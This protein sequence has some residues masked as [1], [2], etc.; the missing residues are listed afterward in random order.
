MDKT[1]SLLRRQLKKIFGSADSAPKDFQRFVDIVN[2]TYFNFDE[3]RLLL[4][5]SIEISSHELV[6]ANSQMRSI[7][8]AIPDMFLRIDAEGKVLEC[9]IPANNVFSHINPKEIV[10]K[11]IYTSFGPLAARRLEWAVRRAVKNKNVEIAEYSVQNQTEQFREARVVWLGDD[12]LIVI[13]RD[14]TERKL[15][16][17]RLLESRRTLQTLMTNLPG[18]AYRARNDHDWTMEFVSEGSVNL[19]GYQP[20]ELVN[21]SKITYNQLI[22]PDE[23]EKVWNTIQ[24]ALKERRHFQIT[25][26]IKTADGE[27]KWVLEQGQGIFSSKGELLAIEGFISDT[28]EKVQMQESIKESESF[29]SEIFASIQD[30]ISVLDPSLNIL[31]TNT[32]MEKWYAHAMPLIG[33]KCYEAYQGRKTRCDICPTC[34]TL[35]TAK[36]EYDVVPKTGID[37]KIIG[38]IDLYSFPL[39]DEKT[40]KLKGVIEYVRDSTETRLAG[41]SLHEIEEKYRAV[42]EATDT[43]FAA[44]DEQGV[45]LNANLNYA[46]LAGYASVNDIIGRNV[47][48]WTT[49]SDIERNRI[50]V[51]N[52]FEKGSVRNLEVDYQHKDGT[53]IT[54]DINA[55]A[56]Q[57][58][59]GKIILALCR[60]ISGRKAARKHPVSAAS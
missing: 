17:D 13:V 14:I 27:Q 34:R 16:E 43:G 56:V 21:K 15:A 42:I 59:N 18:M 38:S 10:G 48:E 55:T 30:G 24:D 39:I 11:S 23:C 50:E 7:F 41:E 58:K 31:R 1:H 54:I 28:T 26:R 6:E 5:R 52:C 20:A 37:G 46:R 60:D 12:Q 57:T 44:I 4:E 22:H 53:V 19:T 49:P 29:L 51:N 32:A 25:Y 36:A 40:G 33:K 47:I 9:R 8:Q 45:V 2:E 35:Q 3:D